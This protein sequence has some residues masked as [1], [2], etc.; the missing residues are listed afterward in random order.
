MGGA[1]LRKGSVAIQITEVLV[2]HPTPHPHTR[3]ANHSPA[4]HNTH[5]IKHTVLLIEIINWLQLESQDVPFFKHF[6]GVSTNGPT[7]L[8]KKQDFP[9]FVFIQGVFFYL[10]IPREIAH[11]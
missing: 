4:I 9:A 10:K 6:L 8:Q 7:V 5:I 3:M 11:S 1:R 2:E